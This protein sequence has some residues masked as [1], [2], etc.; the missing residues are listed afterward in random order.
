MFY[1]PKLV[2]DVFAEFYRVIE[3]HDQHYQESGN[4]QSIS[5][6]VILA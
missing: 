5:P 3:Q 4:D 1:R 6:R 2:D